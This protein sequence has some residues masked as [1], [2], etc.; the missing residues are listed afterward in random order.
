M[1]LPRIVIVFT[2]GTIA[3]RAAAAG[4]NVPAMRGE[5]L[6]TLVPDLARIV[7]AEPIDWGLVPASHLTFDQVL[8]VGRVLR[9]ALAR[10]DVDGAVVVQGTD[11]M[12][13]TA[14]AWDLLPLPAKPVVV[15]G[16][17]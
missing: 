3:M 13:E 9:D 5:E 8:D 1:A 10:Q 12:E 11:V 2:G 4:G 7:D 15:V 16:A 6:L 17:M 14:F